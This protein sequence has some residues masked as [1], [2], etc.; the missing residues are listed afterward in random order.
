MR[1]RKS[2]YSFERFD[3][4]RSKAIDQNITRN[5]LICDNAWW[6]M[7]PPFRFKIKD[8]IGQF[9]DEH[10]EESACKAGRDGL[11]EVFKVYDT[12]SYA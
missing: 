8:R 11:E 3:L 5:R 7:D 4:P 1:P 9:L 6:R 10:V 12:A 2:L